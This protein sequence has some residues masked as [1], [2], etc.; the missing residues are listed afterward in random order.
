MIR[1]ALL[2]VNPASRRGVRDLARVEAALS[3]CGV[4]HHTRRAAGPGDAGD[5]A[6]VVATSYDAVFALGGDGTIIEV[7][8]ALAG[9][10][11]PV[12]PLAAGTGNLLVRALGIPLDPARAVGALCAGH[13]R[14]IDLA[15]LEAGGHF[16]VAAGIGIDVRM[17]ER[18]SPSRKRRFG[19]GAYIVAGAG[20]AIGASARGARFSARIEVDGAVHH[21]EALSIL[22][23]N[24]GSVLNGAITLAPGARPDDGALDVAVYSP[25][26]LSQAVRVAWRML[27]GRFPDD[28][29]TSFY[30]GR[31][32][33]VVTEPLRRTEADGELLRAGVLDATV[34]PGAGRMLVPGWR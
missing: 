27:R 10:A 33:R 31:H 26:T 32:I 23:A 29:L 17:L 22:V 8:G 20:A 13:V 11:V 21:V 3:A 2:I 25:H 28:G 5:L 16:A 18:T 6:R 34:L 1:R 30:R 4:A 9:S 24:V 19:V 12:G 15:R 14:A 7:L